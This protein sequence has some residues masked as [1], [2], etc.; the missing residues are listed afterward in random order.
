MVE[1]I[2]FYIL[3]VIAVIS[4]LLVVTLKNLVHAVL[5]LALFFFCVAGFYV[6]LNAEFLAA[7]QVFVYV[8]GITVL[9]LFL[10]ML[11]FKVADKRLRQVNE[12]WTISLIIVV[13]FGWL[14]ITGLSETNW[15]VTEG[16]APEKAIP[17]IGKLLLTTYVF[18]FEVVSVVLLAA[19][20][21]AMVIARK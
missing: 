10:I 17:A 1:L 14:L 5:S 3:A 20:I 9:F 11:T 18:P 19:L 4:A 7:V 13:L 16:G 6:L 2:S 12:Q 15:V 8:G 21:G